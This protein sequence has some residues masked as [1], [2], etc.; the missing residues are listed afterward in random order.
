M[1][2]E[3][4]FNILKVRLFGMQNRVYLTMFILGDEIENKGPF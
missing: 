2:F 3:L 1:V 4:A